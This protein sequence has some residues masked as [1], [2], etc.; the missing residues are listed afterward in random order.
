VLAT[1]AESLP[2]AARA[3]EE[4]DDLDGGGG[5]HFSS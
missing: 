2:E 5:Q 1:G 4:I 3:G